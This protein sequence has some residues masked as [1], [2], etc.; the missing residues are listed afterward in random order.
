MSELLA[1]DP[2]D[3][4]SLGDRKHKQLITDVTRVLSVF[5]SSQCFSLSPLWRDFKQLSVLSCWARNVLTL[6]KYRESITPKDVG[7]DRFSLSLDMTGRY[8]TTALL[9]EIIPVRCS[10]ET[11]NRV[12]GTGITVECR[13]IKIPANYHRIFGSIWKSTSSCHFQEFSMKVNCLC[14][15]WYI[16]Q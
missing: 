13:Q 8:A 4:L 7:C 6:E 1:S 5:S 12:I 3:L 11:F 10:S 14:C 2:T 9:L 16:L 15:T